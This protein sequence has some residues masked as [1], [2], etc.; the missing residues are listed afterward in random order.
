MIN[1]ASVDQAQRLRELMGKSVSNRKII[2]V[3]SGKGGVGKSSITVNLAIALS[4]LGMRVLVVDADFG[5]ANVDVMLGINA[6]YNMSH[7]IKG[8]KKLHEIIQEGHKGVR[9]ISGGSGVFELLQMEETRLKA[10]MQG[11]I[12]LR[13]PV[14]IILFDMGAGINEN[15]LQLVL[16]SSETIIVTTPEPTSILDAY[17]LIKTILNRERTQSIRVIMNKCENKREAETVLKGF[18]EV[19]RRNLDTEIESLGYVLYDQEVTKSIKRQNPVMISNPDGSAASDIT[20]IARALL[21]LPSRTVGSS[22]LS[23]FFGRLLGE[24]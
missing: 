22:K 20:T 12:S 14:D 24:H 18:Q 11:L 10:I 16:A 3:A 5:L 8:E 21:D 17:A 23:R 4:S 13:E 2:S 7:L 9:F 6:R 1:D 19:V 15:I